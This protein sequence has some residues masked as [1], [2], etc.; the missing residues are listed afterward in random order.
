MNRTQGGNKTNK[1]TKKHFEYMI[2]LKF[3][4]GLLQDWSI[5]NTFRNLSIESIRWYTK[6]YNLTFT[7]IL[8]LIDTDLYLFLVIHHTFRYLF[9][10]FKRFTHSTLTVCHSLIFRSPLSAIVIFLL[11]QTLLYRTWNIMSCLC[12]WFSYPH[13]IFQT[14]PIS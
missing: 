5:V 8:I 13:L 4:K 7:M 2:W 14:F 10:V 3:L 6:S 9:V 1:Q 12:A 11:R